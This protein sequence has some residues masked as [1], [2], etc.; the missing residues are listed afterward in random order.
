[1]KN[2]SVEVCAT[3]I[4]SAL[5]ARIAGANRIELCD[6]IS[7]GGTT[8]SA[9]MIKHCVENLKI[10]TWVMIR[11]RG[12][13]FLYNDIE[14]EVMKH[15]VNIA[16]EIGAEGIV[17]GILRADGTIDL[18][19]MKTIV[20]L[21]DPLKVSFH[22]AFDMCSDHLTA[23]N[24]LIDIGV[25]RILTSGMQNKA[26]DGIELIKQLVKIANGNIEIMAGSGINIDNAK[27][28][29]S[30]TF[31]DALHLTGRVKMFGKMQYKTDKVVLNQFGHEYDFMHYE[32][33]EEII[34]QIVKICQLKNL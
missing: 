34:R 25:V 19:R 14:F 32:T 26:I 29:I 8:P 21:A 7:E 6:N 22:R 20:L 4:N 2:I 30:Q 10:E 27:T 18:E 5:A 3:S 28:I 12:G 16:K 23:V 15:D 31:V 11:P 13:D 33:K 1:M 24:D 9:G 17:T